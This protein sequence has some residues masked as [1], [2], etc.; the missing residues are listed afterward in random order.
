MPDAAVLPCASVNPA[1]GLIERLLSTRYPDHAPLSELA[2][3][4]SLE[5]D[6][7]SVGALMDAG[8]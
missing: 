6:E 8:A 4:L 2:G 5:V 7:L 3:T 1:F